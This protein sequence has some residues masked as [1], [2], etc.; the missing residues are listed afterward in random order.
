MTIKM[1]AAVSSNG[2]I[3]KND[4][5]PFDYP[6]DM[7]FFRKMTTDSAVIMGRKTWEG[8]GKLLPKRRN[9]VISRSKVEFEGLETFS[10]LKEAIENAVSTH[11]NVWLIGGSSIYREGMKFTD[12]IY[13]TLTPDTIEG[14]GLVFFPWIDPTKFEVAHYI[15]LENS[16]SNLKVAK[17][18]N[19]KHCL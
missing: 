16:P 12:E 2:V 1:I 15:D 10:W 11:D 3:G 14:D 7:K 13:L 8:I 9:I 17:Y 4:A 6:E 18:V 5:L 19:V